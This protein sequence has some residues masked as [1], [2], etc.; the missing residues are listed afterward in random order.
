MHWDDRPTV[1]AFG[2]P[3]V[4]RILRQILRC[5]G[6]EDFFVAL[7]SALRQQRIDSAGLTWLSANTNATARDA[8]RLARRDADSG[9]ESLVRW[10]MRS[11]GLS[12]R[13]QV[14]IP[15]VGV[16]DLV[17]GESLIVETDGRENH[18]DES[19]RHKDLVRDANAAA[20][21]YVT[22]RFDYA[23]VVHSWPIVERAI[24]GQIAAGRHL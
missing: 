12:V 19:H 14:R 20:L 15:T 4:P 18:A 16:V 6:V 1:H 17:I 3:S 13:T 7:E 23:L 21:G 5:C 24:L 9:L 22:L 8:I 2:M 10:R 11:H